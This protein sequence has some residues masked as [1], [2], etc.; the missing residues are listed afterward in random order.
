MGGKTKE[1]RPVPTRPEKYCTRYRY[2][3]TIGTC[4]GGRNLED[5]YRMTA[6]PP[7]PLTQTLAGPPMDHARKRWWNGSQERATCCVV[8]SLHLQA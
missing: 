2:L 6:G 7:C 4:R 5:P 1:Q 8:D 3:C